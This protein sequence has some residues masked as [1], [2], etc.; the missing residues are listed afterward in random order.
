MVLVNSKDDLKMGLAP[1]VGSID[2]EYGMRGP[3]LEKTL[4]EMRD[5]F[6]RDMEL[7]G[8]ILYKDPRLPNPKWVTSEDGQPLAYFDVDWNAE[9]Q[10]V[11]TV[12]G[13]PLPRKR[14]TSLEE[15][16]GWV[17]YRIVG[18]FWCPTTKVEMLRSKYERYAREKAEKNPV[19][20]VVNNTI[21]GEK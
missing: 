21:E 6:V 20:F 4:N 18:I 14:A 13:N 3:E 9:R 17:E 11:Q 8:N 1:L 19:N 5:K 10:K 2:L 12:D 15:S 7:R 16:R